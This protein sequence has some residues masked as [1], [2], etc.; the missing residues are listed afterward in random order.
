MVSGTSIFRIFSSGCMTFCVL[1]FIWLMLCE[2][3][4]NIGRGV[5]EIKTH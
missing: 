3:H 4:K 1:S 2:F 5:N